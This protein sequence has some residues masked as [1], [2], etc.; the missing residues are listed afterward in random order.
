MHSL[1][2]LNTLSYGKRTIQNYSKG[3]NPFKKIL[4][5][6]TVG[7]ASSFW[8]F[9]QLS[10]PTYKQIDTKEPHTESF[11]PALKLSPALFA[12]ETSEL[13]ANFTCPAK[14]RP[15]ITWSENFDKPETDWIFEWTFGDEEYFQWEI[16]TLSEKKSF[17]AIDPDNVSSLH[18]EGSYRNWERGSATAT[19]PE[20]AI[21]R[22]ATLTYHVGY[23]LNFNTDCT[24]TLFVS[25][26]NATWEPRWSSLDETGEKPWQWRKVQVDMAAYAGK[27]VRLKFEYGNSQAYDNGGK[28]GSFDIDGMELEAAGNTEKIDAQTGE[29]IKFADASTGTP[30]SWQ[31][32]FPGAIPDK[33]NE[34]YPEV[35]YT[36]DGDYDV[37]L[38]VSDGVHTSTKTIEKFVSVTG[39]APTAKILPPAIFHYNQTRLPM[40]A[41]MVPVT[42]NDASEGYPTEW[43]WSFAGITEKAQDVSTSHEQ[44]PTVS[45]QFLHEQPIQLSVSNQHGSSETSTSVS[46]EYS[47][48]INNLQPNDV[49]TTFD[50]GDGYGNFPGSNKLEMTDYAEKFSKP[51]QPMEVY[52]AYV[53][54]TK[55]AANELIDQIADVQV[56]LCRSENGF[57]GE[58]L[59]FTSWR[60]FELDLPSSSQLVGTEFSFSKPVAVDH[61]F[62]ITV[63]GI[64][65]K[66][67]GTDVAF[68]M[69]KFRSEGNTAYFKQRGEWKSAAEYF[70][71]GANHTSFAI[72][73]AIAHSVMQPLCE[74]PLIVDESAGT[75]EL[76][77]FSYLGYETPI[78]ID[79]DWCR[80]T[81]KPNGLTVDTLTIAY[82]QLPPE[83]TRRT[84]TITLTDGIS[85]V[86]VELVQQALSHVDSRKEAEIKIIPTL[87]HNEFAIELPNK[88]KSIAI[89]DASGRVVKQIDCTQIGRKLIDS[90]S[91]SRGL[92]IIKVE[93]A[94]KSYMLKGI[95]Q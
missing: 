39:I 6:L 54:F 28:T 70:P 48:L 17:S 13:T 22:N 62:F 40:V 73:P 82:D 3:L 8:G 61:E 16:A 19:S 94:T 72:Y 29:I 43:K 31:W 59:E 90:S 79:A 42:F 87:F 15:D 69:A 36:R 21:G 86:D 84:A 77:M 12:A 38:T 91:F 95:K 24:L 23:S 27:N 57:P 56:A 80:I 58:K 35:Y 34:Q 75:T 89:I 83:M 47:G 88:A 41:P 76:R 11:V 74:T 26:D 10:S 67:D 78:S 1:F 60:V 85:Q 4:L 65:E 18:I 71:A 44:H 2:H 52:G 32:H 46:V 92:Y 37:S 33:S 45:Y 93:T 7:T 50:L 51:S 30:T 68:A 64:P 9:S 14:S 55:A 53:Y 81:D 20:I 49:L 5:G 25:T 66:S 63:S